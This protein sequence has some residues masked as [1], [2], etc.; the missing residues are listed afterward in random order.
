MVW[1][2][3][4]GH[5][6]I[7]ILPCQTP[8]LPRQP[9][10]DPLAPTERTA[11]LGQSR[12]TGLTL[13]SVSCWWG[14]LSSLTDCWDAWKILL[15]TYIPTSRRKPR[16]MQ[17][18]LNPNHHCCTPNHL[19]SDAACPAA[20]AH[21]VRGTPR[22]A[23]VSYCSAVSMR[24][25][26]APTPRYSMARTNM[27]DIPCLCPGKGWIALQSMEPPAS[28]SWESSQSTSASPQA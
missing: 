20:P 11:L 26:R 5:S 7:A 25:A 12:R 10:K 15:G 4:K 1:L 2:W 6:P 8:S 22:G 19:T 17:T 14:E 9:H 28:H 24:T 27:M 21:P 16:L 13:P 18:L 3:S 23:A